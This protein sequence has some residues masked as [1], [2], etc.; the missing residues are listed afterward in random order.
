MSKLHWEDFVEGQ[1]NEYGPRHVSHDEIV[2]FAREFDPQPFHLDDEAAK[3]TMFGGLA[4]SGWHTCCLFMRMI[5]DG[6]VNNSASMGAPGV[7]EV[8]WLMP[9]RPGDDLTL[10]ATVLDTRASKSRP[11]MGF[12]RF[13]FEMLNA[14]GAVVMILES[15]LM[16]GLRGADR[17]GAGA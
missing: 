15:S 13:K 9:V 5:A 11:D 6:F 16:Q 1:V 2:E 8:K 10:R 4:A 14:S 12:V 3:K 17:R 7:D